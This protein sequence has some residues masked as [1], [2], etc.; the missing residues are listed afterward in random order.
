MDSVPEQDKRALGFHVTPKRFQ[1]ADLLAIE[2]IGHAARR[3]WTRCAAMW[4]SVFMRLSWR[5]TEHAR[6]GFGRM[7][8]NRDVDQRCPKLVRTSVRPG[9]YR[10]THAARGEL[11]AS[12]PS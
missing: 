1:H 5:L 12:P 2:Q 8:V 11:L 3:R 10:V 4:D 9:K 7:L 6:A